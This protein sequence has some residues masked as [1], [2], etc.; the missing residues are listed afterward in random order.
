[1]KNRS[2]VIL[3]CFMVLFAILLAFSIRSGNNL[4]FRRFTHFPAEGTSDSIPE[5]DTSHD[6][7]EDRVMEIVLKRIPGAT[8][9]DIVRLDYEA[10]GPNIKYDGKAVKNKVTYQFTIDG[11][12]GSILKWEVED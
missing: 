1:M 3:L 9:E 8:S 5:A 4:I 10:E 11:R 7:G 12:D 6:I 2:F